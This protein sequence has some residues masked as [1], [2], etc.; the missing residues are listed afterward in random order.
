[1]TAVAAAMLLAGCG[2]GG[3][4]NANVSRPWHAVDSCLEQNLAFI[5]NVVTDNTGGRGNRGVLSVEG[6]GGALAN[7]FRFQSHAAA[8]AGERGIGPPGP[9]VTYYGDLALEVNAS[10]SQD[11]ATFIQSCFSQVYGA[12]LAVTPSTTTT[13]TTTQTC[14]GKYYTPS[15]AAAGCP[16]EGRGPKP[17]AANQWPCPAGDTEMTN[18]AGPGCTG[19]VAPCA[20]GCNYVPSSGPPP[21][22]VPNVVNQLVDPATL[23]LQQRG[24]VVAATK[25]V[26]SQ[27]PGTVLRQI[28]ASGTAPQGST[29]TLTVAQAPPMVR[30]PRLVGQTEAAASA[31]LGKLGLTPQPVIETKSRNPGYDGLVLSQKPPAHT[32]VP[33][34]SVVIINVERYVAPTSTSSTVSSTASTTTSS[35]PS[36]TA[37]TSSGAKATTPSLAVAVCKAEIQKLGTAALT[38]DEKA[39]LNHLCDIA[40]SGNAAQIKAAEKQICVTVIKDSAPGLSGSALTAAEQSCSEVSQ[41]PAG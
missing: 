32:S 15:M 29:V 20:N 18:S 4:A 2:S 1:M 37:S 26:S 12:T 8:V 9:T 34:G 30:L 23:L 21:V 11:D 19:P 38:A 3:G 41:T 28:P 27:P 40:G 24:F 6:S 5:G 13:T 22:A 17:T 14:S 36:S 10:T 7:A 16:T 39:Q 25:L 33:P 31:L 35:T